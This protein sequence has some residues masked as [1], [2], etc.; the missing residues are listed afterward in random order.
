[1]LINFSFRFTASRHLYVPGNRPRL[2]LC[3]S[4]RFTGKKAQDRMYHR[5][6][7]TVVIDHVQNLFLPPSFLSQSTRM[8]TWPIWLGHPLPFYSFVYELS[9]K[10]SIIN[11]G[12]FGF[13]GEPR[14]VFWR[15]ANFNRNRMKFRHGY[16]SR[17]RCTGHAIGDKFF[18]S[19]LSNTKNILFSS[20][21]VSFLSFFLRRKKR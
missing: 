10:F 11:R 20:N 19:S 16:R 2:I 7:T 1:M 17:A 15:R 3:P 21:N 4:Q 12:E 13:Q 14:Q 9:T 8:R 5:A 6:I 18:F